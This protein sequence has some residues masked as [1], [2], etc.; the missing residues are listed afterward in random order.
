M[1]RARWAQRPLLGSPWVLKHPYCH[2]MITQTQPGQRKGFG[3]GRNVKKFQ[4]S[5]NSLRNGN[6]GTFGGPMA[7]AT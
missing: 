2:Q 7:Q 6:F 3:K 5:L 1:A 4:L